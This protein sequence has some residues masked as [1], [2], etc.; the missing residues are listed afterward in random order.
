MPLAREYATVALWE[1]EPDNPEWRDHINAL[2]LAAAG[3]AHR[4]AE[5]PNFLAGPVLVTLTC[6]GTN[7]AAFVPAI[8][9]LLDPQF[10]DAANLTNLARRALSQI[11][12]PSRGKRP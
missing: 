1:R 2:L 9:R 3:P 10:P 11:D 4:G 8:K 12:P 7:A 6:H 5:D